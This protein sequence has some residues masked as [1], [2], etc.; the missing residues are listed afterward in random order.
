MFQQRKIAGYIDEYA[1]IGMKKLS[2]TIPLKLEAAL[3]SGF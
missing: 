2:P 1:F 3:L